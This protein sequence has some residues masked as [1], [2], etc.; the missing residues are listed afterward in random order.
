MVRGSHANDSFRGRGNGYSKRCDK[1]RYAT[2]AYFDKE[3]CKPFPNFAFCYC[4]CTTSKED[5]DFSRYTLHLQVDSNYHWKG[6]RGANHQ[7]QGTPC[8]APSQA[9][10]IDSTRLCTSSLSQRILAYGSIKT[11]GQQKGCSA[12]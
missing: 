1:R 10:V 9:A 3:F 8:S 12:L 7:L 4:R 2:F 6:I 5:Q 11:D